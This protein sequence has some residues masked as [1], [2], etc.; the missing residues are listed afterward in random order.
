MPE[1]TNTDAGTTTEASAEATAAK[2]TRAPKTH[3]LDIARGR[4]PIPFVHA[5]RFTEPAETGNAALAKKYGTSV[6]KV[7]D[8]RKGRNFGYV[9][10]DYVFNADELNAA[11]AWAHEAGNHGGDKDALV[12]FVD[13]QTVGDAAAVAAQAAA[14]PKKVMPPR[15]PKAEK[16]QAAESVGGASGAD[17]LS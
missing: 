17:L 4:L 6:G 2:K 12:A 7:F 5:I 3:L 15:K 13:S 14:K 11:R 8:I 10:K 9:T 16:G 1:V